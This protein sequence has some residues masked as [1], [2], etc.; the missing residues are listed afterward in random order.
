MH[1]KNFGSSRF[2]IRRLGAFSPAKRWKLY[3]ILRKLGFKVYKIYHLTCTIQRNYQKVLE[4]I[5][6]RKKRKLR[7]HAHWVD[8][9]P[10][11]IFYL[12]IEIGARKDTWARSDI[13]DNLALFH[14]EVFVLEEYEKDILSEYSWIA[15][16]GDSSINNWQE[17]AKMLGTT[18]FR[19]FIKGMAKAE[20]NIPKWY[21]GSGGAILICYK[22]YLW[23]DDSKELR[24]WLCRVSSDCSRYLHNI[25]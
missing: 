10:P 5:G 12:L 22:Y 13:K 2:K 17:A 25:F 21:G 14:E 9:I 1:N 19:Y 18:D 16:L 8:E 23:H 15:R 3:K 20:R 11:K 24:T 6:L 7:L 4:F